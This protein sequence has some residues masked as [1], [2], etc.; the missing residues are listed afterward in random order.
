MEFMRKDRKDEVKKITKKIYQ[1][2]ED[3]R[4]EEKN[5][6]RYLSTGRKTRKR[7]ALLRN[8][9]DFINNIKGRRNYNFLKK[10]IIP[11]LNYYHS[12]LRSKA[13]KEMNSNSS[14]SYAY[15]ELLYSKAERLKKDI[16]ELQK[17]IETTI[18]NKNNSTEYLNNT[19]NN[20]LA[21]KQKQYLNNHMN[22]LI[23]Y[24]PRGEY[25]IVFE[26][27]YG[28]SSQFVHIPNHGKRKVRYQKNGRAYVIV[29][30]K[31]LKLN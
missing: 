1:T 3:D 13:D 12:R 23:N 26:N 11:K 19:S 20:Y 17:I 30:K 14:M 16:N 4:K 21:R 22:R 27:S 25:E 8:L 10:H 6:N 15:S 7:T 28:G 31:K 2:L 5:D 18:T 9:Y 24:N 29:N